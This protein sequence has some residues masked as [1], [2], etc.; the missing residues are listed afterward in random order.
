MLASTLP[1]PVSCSMGWL[2]DSELPN[3]VF[4]TLHA[5]AAAQSWREW[6]KESHW[7]FTSA[8]QQSLGGQDLREAGQT[9]WLYGKMGLWK[10]HRS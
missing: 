1:R 3:L 2:G 9:R 7:S 5:K 4:P 8:V 10:P 6:G